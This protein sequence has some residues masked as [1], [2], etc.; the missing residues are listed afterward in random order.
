[1]SWFF[2]HKLLLLLIIAG[3]W[4]WNKNPSDRFGM[5]RPGFVIYNR[6]PV[7]FT[8]CYISPNGKLYLEEDLSKEVNVNYWI[9]NHLSVKDGEPLMNTP[10]LVGTGFKDKKSIIFTPEQMKRLHDR[11]FSL[12]LLSS[13]DVIVKYNT[14]VQGGQKTGILL[15]IQ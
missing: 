11:H 4:Y 15:K 2:K 5:T 6:I 7:F 1:M 10:I 14:V 12:E 8:D 13:K 9:D 3:V